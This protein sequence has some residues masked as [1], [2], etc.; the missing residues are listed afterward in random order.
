MVN[1]ATWTLFASFRQLRQSSVKSSWILLLHLQLFT[2][3]FIGFM[4]SRHHF[5]Q[6][7]KLCGSK[8]AT[9]FTVG[10]LSKTNVQVHF[11]CALAVYPFS[12]FLCRR[13]PGPNKNVLH[14]RIDKY[15][16]LFICWRCHIVKLMAL[17]Q[18]PWLTALW[19]RPQI[20]YYLIDLI[21][22][23]KINQR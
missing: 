15:S 3:F 4:D 2:S 19:S 14:A 17:C 21:T 23:K 10:A 16:T 1:C 11:Y 13:K 6:Q 20:V 5:Q 12:P 8:T 9:H 22:E 7:L 18:S